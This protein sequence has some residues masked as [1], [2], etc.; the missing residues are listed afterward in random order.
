MH[1]PGLFI[2]SIPSA[3]W[4]GL[5]FIVAISVLGNLVWRGTRFASTAFALALLGE[6]AYG[7]LKLRGWMQHVQY[8]ANHP[9][10]IKKAPVKIGNAVISGGND[11]AFNMNASNPFAHQSPSLLAVAILIAIVIRQFYS[12]RTLNH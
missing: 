3:A 1:V 11:P 4:I 8:Q 5:G 7:F 2:P 12:K 9:S 10:A 6:T